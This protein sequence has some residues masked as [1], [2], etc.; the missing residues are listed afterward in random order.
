MRLDEIHNFWKMVEEGEEE[1]GD[2]KYDS[3]RLHSREFFGQNNTPI[4]KKNYFEPPFIFKN[5]AFVK[6]ISALHKLRYGQIRPVHSG[7]F[8][9]VKSCRRS[10]RI[11]TVYL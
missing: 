9:K 4:K 10:A 6:K 3:E 11:Q 8:S 7:E 2:K 5:M 1:E